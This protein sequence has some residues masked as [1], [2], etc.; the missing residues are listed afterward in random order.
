MTR[1]IETAGAAREH[2]E[3][4]RPVVWTADAGKLAA[5]ITAAQATINCLLDNGPENK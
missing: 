1:G 4:F 2:E 5:W 3:V